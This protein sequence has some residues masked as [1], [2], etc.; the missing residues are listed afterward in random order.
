MNPYTTRTRAPMQSCDIARALRA[1]PFT[2]AVS[3]ATFERQRR[4]R[5]ETE[6]AWLMKQN[7]IQL[8]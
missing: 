7:N 3:L 1:D 6:V 4:W 5:S 8:G 2:G